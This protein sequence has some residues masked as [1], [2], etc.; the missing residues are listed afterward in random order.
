MCGVLVPG[1]Q[2]SKPAL[3]H[4]SIVLT[5]GPPREVPSWLFIGEN[6]TGDYK[7]LN[8]IIQIPHIL[9]KASG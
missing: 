5:T 2:G 3:P 9:Y 8:D 6:T 4:R 1:G 7:D